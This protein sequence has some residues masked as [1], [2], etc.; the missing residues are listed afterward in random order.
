MVTPGCRGVWVGLGGMI[1]RKAIVGMR[2]HRWWR[3]AMG[4]RVDGRARGS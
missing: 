4:G 2:G 3:G 1:G